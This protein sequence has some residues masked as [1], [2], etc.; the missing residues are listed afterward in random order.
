M[1]GF[2]RK[3]FLSV[4]ITCALM[5]SGIAAENVLEKIVVT[6][7]KREQ[8]IQSVGI[9]V[10]AISGDMMNDLGLDNTQEITQQIPGLQIQTFTPGFTVFNLRGI[11]QN[12]FLDNMEAPVAAYFDESY[13]GSMNAI[14][15]QMFDMERV[16]VLR[17]PQ[18][19]LFGRNATGGLIHFIS[20]KANYDEF[21]GYLKSSIAD[22]N[23]KTFE[24]AFGTALTDNVRFRLAGRLEK[25]NG[26]LEGGANTDEGIALSNE[27]YS[28]FFGFPYE[29]GRGGEGSTVGGSNAYSLRANFQIDFSDATKM[30]LTVSHSKD[31]DAPVGQYVHYL[32]GLDDNGLG[33]KVDVDNPVTGDIHKHSGSDFS[34]DG[35]DTGLDRDITNV[36]AAIYTDLS[37]DIELVSITNWM[38]MDKSHRENAGGSVLDFPFMT[39]ANYNQWSQEIRLSG[40]NDDLQWQVGAYYLDMKVDTLSSLGGLLFFTE[41][42]G[43]IDS[44]TELDSINWSVFSQ[45]EYHINDSFTIIGGLR[46][47]QDDKDI[48]FNIV[49]ASGGLD[50]VDFSPIPNG[51]TLFDLESE[52]V[53]VYSDVPVI[54]YGDYAARLQ[55]NWKADSDTLVFLSYNRGIKGGNWSTGAGVEIE[56]IKHDEE[57]LHAYELGIKT[58]FSDDTIR[59]NATTF[60]YDYKDYQAFSLI[61]FLPQISNTDATNQGGE[62][63]LFLTPTN[64]LDIILGASFINSNIDE[65]DGPFGIV[66]DAELPQAPGYSLNYLLRYN[67]DVSD[68]SFAMQLDGTYNDVQYMESHNGGSSIQDAYGIINASVTYYD[69]DEWNL[70]AWVK[71]LN[72]AKYAIYS[73]DTLGLILRQYGAPTQF[74]VTATYNW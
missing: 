4:S 9:S 59:V 58:S 43:R 22:F 64:N 71:N 12:N 14:A 45:L 20:K 16:E 65:V 41:P 34:V 53:G 74:G 36:T 48:K 44:Y 63:E 46:W 56:N 52:S 60:Y 42:G 10:T 35:I 68:G 7:Q 30:D 40:G 39:N 51:T 69:N 66:K 29:T 23:T 72:D 28:E 47:S 18:G 57:V 13:V 62:I 3:A 21:N 17:G 2:Y 32:V 19:T 1:S 49:S 25:S 27:F 6:A 55:L 73:L 38:E 31:K 50:P 70:S 67:W 33:T 24:G 61:N 8:S 5:G 26:Y 15:G 54:D 11:S 37:E